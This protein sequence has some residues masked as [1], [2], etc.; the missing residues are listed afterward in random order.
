ME[1]RK[2][3]AVISERVKDGPVSTILNKLDYVFMIVN[4]VV[5]LAWVRDISYNDR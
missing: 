3:N 2:S 4:L 1:E 5:C